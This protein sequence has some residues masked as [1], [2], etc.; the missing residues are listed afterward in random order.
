MAGLELVLLALMSTSGSI[1]SVLGSYS[2]HEII[3]LSN[4]FSGDIVPSSTA[5]VH[6]VTVLHNIYNQSLSIEN[7]V[8]TSPARGGFQNLQIK[9]STL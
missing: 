2:G 4:P 9:V 6:P 8:S 5:R 7:F 1:C 3:G